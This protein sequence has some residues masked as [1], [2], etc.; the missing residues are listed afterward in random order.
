[1]M[2]IIV[3]VVAVEDIVH[4]VVDQT[5]KNR[6]IAAV[7]DDEMDQN[8][9]HRTHHGADQIHG[10]DAENVVAVVAAAEMAASQTFALV[11]AHD[12]PHLHESGVE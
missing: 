3:V 10:R 12:T 7:V 1:M 6:H 11:C 2:K 5:D 4:S 8:D 9:H